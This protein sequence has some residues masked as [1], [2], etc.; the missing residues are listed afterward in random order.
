M[1]T[2]VTVA[3]VVV[4]RRQRLPKVFERVGHLAFCRLPGELVNVRVPAAD[5]GKGNLRDARGEIKVHVTVQTGNG[6]KAIA[7]SGGARQELFIGTAMTK[8]ALKER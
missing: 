2:T 1:V 3:Q 6:W 4:E 7:L 8:E 5:I